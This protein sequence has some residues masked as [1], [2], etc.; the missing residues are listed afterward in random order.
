ML[1]DD[2]A[3][4][5]PAHIL[6]AEFDPLRDSGEAYGRR[7]AEAGVPAVVSRQAGHIHGS[8]FLLYPGWEGA[9]RWRDELVAAVRAALT[10][11]P[12]PVG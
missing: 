10:A 12:E 6:T 9:R 7:L 8:S 2:L 3:G 5:P 1:A 4:L 11:A